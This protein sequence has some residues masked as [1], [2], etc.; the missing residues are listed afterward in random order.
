[1]L[2]GRFMLM[3]P[4]LAIAGSLGRK[5]PIAAIGRHVPDEHAAV[6]GA[7]HRCGR[8]RRRAHVLPRRRARPD[9]RAPR[10]KVLRSSRDDYRRR[11]TRRSA[12]RPSRT[13][14]P[15]VRKRASATSMFDPAIM[16]RAVG[17]SFVKLDPRQM[18]RNP[19]MFVVEIG[20]VLTTILFFQKLP[21]GDVIATACSPV[22]SPLALVHRAV[23][24]L[25][26]S[27]RRGARQGAGRHAAQDAVGDRRAGAHCPTARPSTKSSSELT[28]ATSASCPRAS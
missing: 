25:R 22:S 21:L 13:R 5:Q 23:R 20:S 4:V 15:K 28:S 16:R 7:A 27:G 14:P 17:D 12:R 2:V 11:P 24:E 3:I 19:V 9:R 26:R 18:A 10:R 1:M 8:D 6:R